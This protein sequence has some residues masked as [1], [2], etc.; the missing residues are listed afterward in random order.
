M[1]RANNTRS[2]QAETRETEDRAGKEAI[3]GGV[4]TVQ[5]AQGRVASPE[6]SEQSFLQTSQGQGFRQREQQVQRP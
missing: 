1:G 6:L 2:K 5:V 4:A 3:G